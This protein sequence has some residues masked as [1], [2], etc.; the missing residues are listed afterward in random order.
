MT[1]EFPTHWARVT[2]FFVA[3]PA[4]VAASSIVSGALGKSRKFMIS[5]RLPI[6]F[7]SSEVLWALRVARKINSIFISSNIGINLANFGHSRGKV[8]AKKTAP[9]GAVREVHCAQSL[10]PSRKAIREGYLLQRQKTEGKSETTKR[11]DRGK[12]FFPSFCNHGAS[13]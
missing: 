3:F 10:Y 11:P 6:I 5:N 8:K 12:H 2:A 4:K 1:R 7:A 9:Y 13:L